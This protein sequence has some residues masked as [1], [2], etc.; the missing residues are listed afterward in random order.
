MVMED[1]DYGYD[2]KVLSWNLQGIRD[3]L[4][5]DHLKFLNKSHNLDMIFLSET[6]VNISVVEKVLKSLKVKDWFIMPSIGR[7]GG[8]AIAWNQ[9][10]SA[11]LISF[12]DNVFHFQVFKDNMNVFI[13]FMYGSLDNNRRNDQ[14]DFIKSIS[15]VNAPWDIISDMNFILH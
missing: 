5:K 2:F 15:T 1:R 6:K 4:K 7:S 14:W 13:T 3:A 11:K 10:V 9:G 12:K 8:F